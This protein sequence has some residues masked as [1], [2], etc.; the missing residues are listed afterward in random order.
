MPE[1]RDTQSVTSGLHRNGTD[2]NSLDDPLEHV[3]RLL[4]PQHAHLAPTLIAQCVS[5]TE[6]LPACL[7]TRSIAVLCTS[8]IPPTHRIAAHTSASSAAASFWRH[9]SATAATI[10]LRAPAC[11]ATRERERE[12]RPPNCEDD[13]AVW[14]PVLTSAEDVSVKVVVARRYGAQQLAPR[15]MDWPRA[16]HSEAPPPAPS[17]ASRGT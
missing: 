9:L 7:A 17:A 14:E 11:A 6:S 15:P 5:G 10:W 13:S 1:R 2:R 16:A 3:F 12:M 4:P 8:L